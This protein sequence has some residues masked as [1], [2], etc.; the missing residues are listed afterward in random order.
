[1]FQANPELIE[2]RLHLK[3]SPATVFK[4]LNTNE[5]RAKFWAESATEED[6][7]IH[8]RFPDGTLWDA[9]IIERTPPHRFSL[10]YYGGSLTLFTLQDDGKGGTD[11]T[12]RDKGVAA[13]ARSEVLAG[14]VSV[15]MALKAAVDFDVDLR[16][17]DDK[18]TWRDGYVEN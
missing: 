1:M 7:I 2:W 3:S 4:I 17:H 5:G 13:D 9:R 10:E 11:F 15:L 8:F 6:G 18:R 12:L 14:W 16:T